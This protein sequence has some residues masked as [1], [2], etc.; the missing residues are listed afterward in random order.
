MSVIN[1]Y[2]AN[3][4]RDFLS[5][6]FRQLGKS[7]RAFFLGRANVSPNFIPPQSFNHN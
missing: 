6:K 7:V 5:W 4:I 2:K 1:K 3:R